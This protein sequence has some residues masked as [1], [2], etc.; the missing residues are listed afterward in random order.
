[1]SKKTK[2]AKRAAAAQTK[3]NTRTQRP[4]PTPAIVLFGLDEAKKPHAAYFEEAQAELAIKAANLMGLGVL[5]IANREESEL[6]GRLPAGRI[7]ANGRGFVPHFRQDLYAKV[8][9][10]AGS[11]VQGGRNPSASGS[12]DANLPAGRFPRNWDEIDVGHIVI[13]QESDPKDGWFDAIVIS[14]AADMLTLRWRDYPH[15][16]KIV[17]HRLSV[18]LHRPEPTAAASS[19]TAAP[20]N[21]EGANRFP[22][23]WDEIDVDHVVLAREYGPLQAW[24]E[25]IVVKKTGDDFTLR[26]RDYPDLPNVVWSRSQVGLFCPNV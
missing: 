24:W 12:R 1:M 3:T 16:R 17:R 8:V 10:S 11:Q 5:K 22:R 6:A 15:Q 2:Q 23:T 9:E 7:F 13:A 21:A 20:A 19:E 25:A 18:G 26:W 14:K 4:V